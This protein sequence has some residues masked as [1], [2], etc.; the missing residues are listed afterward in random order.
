MYAD[1]STGV[2]ALVARQVNLT[3]AFDRQMRLH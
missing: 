2:K 3:L 1:S